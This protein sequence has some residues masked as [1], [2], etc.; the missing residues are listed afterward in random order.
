[1]LHIAVCDDEQRQ[2]SLIKALLQEYQVLH[3]E[4]DLRVD[5]F[6]SDVTLLEHL[7]GN[8]GFDLYLLDV[9]MPESNGIELGIKLRKMD[10]GG[11]L[12]YLTTSPDYAIDSYLAKASGYLLKPI[13]KEVLFPILDNSIESWMR[14]HQVF[15]TIKARNGLQRLSLHT[16]VYCE[17]V[18]HCVQY[19]LTDGSVLSGMSVRTSFREAVA[20]FLEH[21]RFVLCATSFFVNLSF[22][23]MI[24]PAGLKLMN[25]GTLPLSRLMRMDVTNRW[26][27]YH[28]KCSIPPGREYWGRLSMQRCTWHPVLAWSGGDFRPHL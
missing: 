16:V 3:P 12:L 14:E 28:L 7:R 17:L 6:T 13:R 11:Q 8:G 2:L 25:G 4:L 23:D 26:L 9:L 22:V 10:Q 15:I 1:M 5:T 20:D 24:E 27:D 18:G 19:H 21:D